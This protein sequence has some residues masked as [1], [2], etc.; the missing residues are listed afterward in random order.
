MTIR[1]GPLAGMWLAV[2]LGAWARPVH[3]AWS[4]PCTLHQTL[5]ARNIKKEVRVLRSGPSD[6]QVELED[7][8]VQ[9]QGHRW[10]Y[11]GWVEEQGSVNVPSFQSE[12]TLEL[13]PQLAF[14]WPLGL[15]LVAGL[16]ALSVKARRTARQRRD[17]WEAEALKAE[18]A[19]RSDDSVPQQPFGAFTCQ[20]L[21][22]R[23]GMGVVY[24]AQ[25]QDGTQAAIK[26][27]NQEISDDPEFRLRYQ[28]EAALG[29]QLQ[30][31]HL[32]RTLAAGDQPFPHIVLEWVDGN[33]LESI[34][35]KRWPGEWQRTRRWTEQILDA[36][37]YLHGRNLIHRDIKPA[38]VMLSR[39]GVVK[40]MDLGIV[41]KL[42]GTR[43][44]GTH[45]VLGSPPYMAPEQ[46]AGSPVTTSIDLYSLGVLV[47][48]RLC[49][50]S[51]FPADFG[52]LIQAKLHQDVPTLHDV[53]FEVPP[54]V[55]GFVE[56]LMDRNPERRFASA[57]DALK[58]LRRLR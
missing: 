33:T 5:V 9:L 17:D 21:L 20:Q 30:H 31:R 16:T 2:S 32:V 24:R 41:H 49:G 15:T 7:V 57:Q 50:Y 8:E 35:S 48:E 58:A 29:M 44:T 38:N 4:H 45:Q 19:V 47:Y 40:L 54:D 34:P 51:P 28:R 37:V 18:R 46:L 56:Q 36:L 14:Y 12:V 3:V 10:A 1:L 6:A 27:P 25:S 53:D 52:A 11:A 13:K 42:Q 43:L 55:S 23:G 22:G 26:V 39:D